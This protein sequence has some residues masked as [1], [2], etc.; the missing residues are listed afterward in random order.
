MTIN[1]K[2][3]QNAGHT[4]PADLTRGLQREERAIDHRPAEAKHRPVM[5]P[6]ATGNANGQNSFS[7]SGVELQAPRSLERGEQ[8]HGCLSSVWSRT[9]AYGPCRIH[10]VAIRFPPLYRKS[11]TKGEGVRKPLGISPPDRRICVV[12]PLPTG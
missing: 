8:S 3:R 11:G 1:V 6:L 4:Y 7:S 2:K 9:Y 12:S 10:W 5:V